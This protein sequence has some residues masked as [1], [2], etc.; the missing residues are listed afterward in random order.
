MS[1]PKTYEW[2]EMPRAEFLKNKVDHPWH[3]AINRGCDERREAGEEWP[4]FMYDAKHSAQEV[5]RLALLFSLE[6]TDKLDKTFRKCSCCTESKHVVDNII[7][8]VA[9]VW[10]AES[11][12]I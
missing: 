9:L 3:V 11:V 5:P 10:S 1:E 2:P 4:R 8:R 12:H 7:S 6:R